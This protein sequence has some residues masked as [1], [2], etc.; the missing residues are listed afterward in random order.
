MLGKMS[1]SSLA[2][3]VLPLDEAPLMPTTMQLL[4]PPPPACLLLLLSAGWGVDSAMT[5]DVLQIMVVVVGAELSP[6]PS[7]RTPI[8]LV[9]INVT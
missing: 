2:S 6:D 7:L 5:Y 1:R 9:N 3:V 8:F 4:G